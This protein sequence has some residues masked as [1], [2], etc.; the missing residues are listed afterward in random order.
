MCI[1]TDAADT[2]AVGA[3]SAGDA[4]SLGALDRGDARAVLAR[5]AQAHV[6]LEAHQREQ[7]QNCGTIISHFVAGSFCFSFYPRGDSLGKEELY[8]ACFFFCMII[9]TD[10]RVW[11]SWRKHCGRMRLTM[12]GEYAIKYLVSRR[13]R[14]MILRDIS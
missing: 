8:F 5:H 3:G 6:V 12:F 7:R 4:A 13:G 14:K 2:V 1:I 10:C 11:E 9:V